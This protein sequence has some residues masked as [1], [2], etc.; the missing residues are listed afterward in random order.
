MTK[1]QTKAVLCMA[2]LCFTSFGLLACKKLEGTANL[3]GNTLQLENNNGVCAVISRSN[4]GETKTYQAGIPWPCNFHKNKSGSVRITR[5]RQYEYL[6]IESSKPAGE[7][8]RDCETH[9]QSIRAQGEQLQVSQ[10][11]EKVASCPPFQ[12]DEV[13][14]TELFD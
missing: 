13:L 10:H 8:S 1:L 11:Q 6:L 12:W 14:F 2:A 7:N 4:G 5:N 3:A 9:L